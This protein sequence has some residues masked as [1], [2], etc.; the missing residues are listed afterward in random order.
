MSSQVVV[1]SGFETWDVAQL[2]D[3]AGKTYLITGGNAG[4]G[5][6]TAV[7]LGKAGGDLVLAC[8]SMEKGE[9]AKAALQPLVKGKVD[10]LQLDLSDLASV[11]QAANQAHE[12][13]AKLDALINNAGIMQTP[14]RKTADGFELQMGTNHLG[15]FLLSGLLLDLVEAAAGRFVTLTSIAHKSAALN[16]DDLMS[17]QKYSPTGAYTQSKVANLMFA[18]ELD[19]RLQAAGSPAI[20]IAAHPGYSNT[21][22]QSTGP[23][24]LLKCIYKV[25]N[26]MAQ[27]P[28]QGAHPTVLAAAGTEAKRGGFYGPQKMAEFRGPAG[29]AKAATHA[30][31]KDAWKRLWERSEELVGFQWTIPAT[32]A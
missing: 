28:E 19:R 12:K 29:D 20:S 14:P 7:H 23:T 32:A 5:Y 27:S 10:L 6:E 21:T 26:L 22:L 4:L 1:D 8:R 17:E 24:G 2:P 9:K 16:L 30:L 31:D 3:L 13:Y 25:A 18:F 15:H 11:R